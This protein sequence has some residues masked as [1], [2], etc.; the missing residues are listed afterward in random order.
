ML[1][2]V[3]NI[4]ENE[5]LARNF[6]RLLSRG[7]LGIYQLL[8]APISLRL[9]RDEEIEGTISALPKLTQ[10]QSCGTMCYRR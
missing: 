10:M 3:R 9:Y 7:T 2:H 5:T 4:R 8:L 6:E 1:R